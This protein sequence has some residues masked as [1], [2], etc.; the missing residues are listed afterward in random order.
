M[1]T[2]STEAANRPKAL[3]LFVDLWLRAPRATFYGGALMRTVTYND[4][5]FCTRNRAGCPRSHVIIAFVTEVARKQ[6]YP[7]EWVHTWI[8]AW[9]DQRGDWITL[10]DEAWNVAVTRF[11]AKKRQA[12]KKAAK[13][14]A[15]EKELLDRIR[16]QVY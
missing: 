5:D 2:V 3:R 16:A 11:A 14:E 10:K 8:A 13:K 15:A 7:T 6:G 1:T 9:I 12:D 4:L